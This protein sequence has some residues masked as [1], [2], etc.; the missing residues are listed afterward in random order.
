MKQLPNIARGDGPQA[1]NHAAAITA[2]ILGIVRHTLLAWLHHDHHANR[3]RATAR[4]R[5]S[6]APSSKPRRA[7]R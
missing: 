5:R 4:S 6:C 7:K 2:E 1:Q 3:G